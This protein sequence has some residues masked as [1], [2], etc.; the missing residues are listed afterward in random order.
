VDIRLAKLRVQFK[1]VGVRDTVARLRFQEKERVVH[2]ITTTVQ[3]M[4]RKPLMK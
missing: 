3:E 1:G 2:M 4:R